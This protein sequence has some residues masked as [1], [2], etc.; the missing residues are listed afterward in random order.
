[1]RDYASLVC[2]AYRLLAPHKKEL[3]L[4]EG[5][6]ERLVLTR[7]LLEEQGEELLEVED[8]RRKPRE[9]EGLERCRQLREKGNKLYKTKKLHEAVAVYRYLLSRI[10]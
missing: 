4:V 6:E 9:L 5:V 1:M 10:E 2:Q 7:R 8:W 3:D